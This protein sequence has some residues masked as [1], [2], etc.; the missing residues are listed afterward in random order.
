MMKD[1]VAFLKIFLIIYILNFIENIVLL[2]TFGLAL[3]K[4]SLIG[5]AVFSLVFTILLKFM[6]IEI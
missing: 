4:D 5:T 1:I 2:V 6:K 3:T